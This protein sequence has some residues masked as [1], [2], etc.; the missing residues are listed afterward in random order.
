MPLS[1]AMP[2]ADVAPIFVP[3]DVVKTFVQTKEPELKTIFD[4]WLARIVCFAF[5]V[6][7]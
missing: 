6:S 1:R 4:D 5:S 3:G 7:P 2:D